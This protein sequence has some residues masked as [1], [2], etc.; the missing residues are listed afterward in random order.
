MSHHL[1]GITTFCFGSKQTLIVGTRTKLVRCTSPH[2][3]SSLAV[4]LSGVVESRASS[5]LERKDV[6]LGKTSLRNNNRVVEVATDTVVATPRACGHSSSFS[7]V[8]N[9]GFFEKEAERSSDPAVVH[10]TPDVCPSGE[11]FFKQGIDGALYDEV[12]DEVI[13]SKLID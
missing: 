6:A 11:A 1:F 9:E 3:F 8:T 12:R 5:H 10:K 4:V 7:L 2:D 13:V